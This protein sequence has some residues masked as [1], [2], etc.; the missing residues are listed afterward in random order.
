VRDRRKRASGRMM[1]LSTAGAKPY[2]ERAEEIDP[3]KVIP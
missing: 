1:L 3:Q 2:D